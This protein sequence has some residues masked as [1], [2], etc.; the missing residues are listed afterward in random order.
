MTPT[1]DMLCPCEQTSAKLANIWV[2]PSTCDRRQWWS[3]ALFLSMQHAFVVRTTKGM[4]PEMLEPTA[5]RNRSSLA[6][7][8]PQNETI[9]DDGK[10]RMLFH[11]GA[12]DTN[13]TPVRPNAEIKMGCWPSLQSERNGSRPLKGNP[14]A[15]PQEGWL[16]AIV[17]VNVSPQ[18]RTPC[19]L[20]SKPS[21]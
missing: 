13:Q 9:D 4:G 16:M 17:G 6:R 21:R 15:S 7:I 11:V 5:R 18:L 8:F 3:M 14:L 12:N 10:P 20:I 19:G 1:G 2:P